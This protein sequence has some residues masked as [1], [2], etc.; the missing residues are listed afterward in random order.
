[1]ERNSD[2]YD[3]LPTIP[4]EDVKSLIDAASSGDTVQLP[5]G[6]ITFTETIIIPSSK[7]IIIKG[8]GIDSTVITSNS[9]I[10]L[11][12]VNYNDNSS[13]RITDITFLSAKEGTTAL[14][15]FGLHWRIDHCSFKTVDPSIRVEAIYAGASTSQ[16]HPVGLIDHC[17]FTD[18]RIVVFGGPGGGYLAHKNWNTPLGLGTDNAVFVEDNIF[19]KIGGNIMDSNYAGRYV[20]RYNIIND[21]Q[22]MTHSVQG[23]N[24]A[25]RSW[26]IYNNVFN[27]VNSGNWTPFFIRGGTGVIFNNVINGYFSQANITIDNVR[28]CEDKPVCGQADGTSPWDGIN[29][30]ANGYPAR[31]Q[32]GRSGDISLWTDQNPYPIQDSVPAYSWN[33]EWRYNGNT[34]AVVFYVHNA[35]ADCNRNNLF[36][37]EGRDFN[38]YNMSIDYP[39]YTPYTYPHP[40]GQ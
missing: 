5:V 35:S 30:D 25:S 38:N 34:T 31:D 10:P 3:H 37:V 36:L 2:L 4:F 32:I 40:L 28:S 27:A 21:S 13:T 20:F 12:E 29:Q 22:V 39:A 17:D 18:S 15:V 6:F 24:R 19:N 26:E 7:S 14:K 16:E 33:N 8:M 1:M 9:A 11:I 23:Y